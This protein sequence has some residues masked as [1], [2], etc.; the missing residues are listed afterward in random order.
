MSRK[1][2][3]RAGLVQAALAGKITNQEGAGALRLSVRQFKRLKARVRAEGVRGLLHRARGHPSRR[4]L[5]PALREQI[6]ALM[7]STYEG[8]NDAH[9]TEKL[10]EQHALPVSRATVRRVRLA[11]GRPARRRRRAPQHR[12]R[13]ERAPAMGLLVQLDASP[14]AWLE[15]RGPTAT[16]H[17]LIDDATS[18]PLALWFRPTED[19]HGYLTVLGQTCRAYGLPITLYGDRLNLFQR[20]DA[21]WTLDEQLRGRQ[22][23]THF[24]RILEELGI[25]FI[26]AQSP[27]AKGRIERLWRTLQDRLVS[28]LRLRRISTIVDANA[29]LPEF[30]ADF[31][32]RFSRPPSTPAPAWRPAPRDLDRVLSCRYYR[33]V[34]HDNTVHIGPRWIQ[35]PPGPGGRSYARCQ[36]EVREL[37]DGRLL[38]FYQTLLLATQPSPGPDFALTPRAHP[39]EA[40]ERR[41][42]K[43]RQRRTELEHAVEAL[44]QVARATPSTT[45]RPPVTG[46]SP[47]REALRASTPHDSEGA[48]DVHT[49]K[50][51]TAPRWRPPLTHPWKQTPI[52]PRGRQRQRT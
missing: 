8:F 26:P 15:D 45:L 50:H 38:V 4:R 24:G 35:I 44:T 6:V 10:Q 34:S 23:P 29:F 7:T 11:L 39:G 36:V 27:Q 42:R 25:G 1:E 30:L 40:R 5:P 17:G 31:A 20:N 3:P 28:E 22:D 49:P 14:F 2:V 21:Y 48:R 9:L 37:L 43:Q 12:A 41:R 46:H 51:G 47:N 52:L 32:P 33:L 19:L 18:R 13:R 16:L